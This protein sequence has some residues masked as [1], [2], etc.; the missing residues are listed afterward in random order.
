MSLLSLPVEILHQIFLRVDIDDVH[1]ARQTCKKLALV[2]SDEYFRENATNV[3]NIFPGWI[4]CFFSG[5]TPERCIAEAS[6]YFGV[7]HGEYRL[8]MKEEGGNLVVKGQYHKGCRSGEWKFYYMTGVIIA[9]G[10]FDSNGEQTGDWNYYDDIYHT[11]EEMSKGT[12][13]GRY[14]VTRIEDGNTIT[15]GQ[16]RDGSRH[17]RWT[18]YEQN[19]HNH[20]LEDGEI[21]ED[22]IASTGIYIRGK[23]HG[24]WYFHNDGYTAQG[25]FLDGQ[26]VGSWI[27][28]IRSDDGFTYPIV[29]NTSDARQ[30]LNI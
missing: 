20:Q 30:M 16:Y 8:W 26:I 21:I 1:N 15:T 5:Y 17:G 29:L 6:T 13:H 2:L 28:I 24:N 7:L 19:Q 12:R 10:S 4:N 14:L 22:R 18:N 27:F 11:I 25:E 23:R 9:R 3:E